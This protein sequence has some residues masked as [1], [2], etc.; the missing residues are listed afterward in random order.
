MK[1]FKIFKFFLIVGVTM[2]L[3]MSNAQAFLWPTLDIKAIAEALKNYEI[4]AEQTIQT[5]EKTN[6]TGEILNAVGGSSAVA[7]AEDAKAKAEKLKKKA[8]KIQKRA[9]WLQKKKEQYEALKKK[10]DKAKEKMEKYV[11]QGK[12]YYEEGKDAYNN[13]K[14]VYDA[15]DEGDFEETFNSGKNLYDGIT[16]EFNQKKDN[17]E[18][19][20]ETPTN[21][22]ET[23]SVPEDQSTRRPFD[24]QTVSRLESSFIQTESLAFAQI[25][26]CDEYKTGSNET[27]DFIFS[28]IIANKCCM[29]LEDISLENVQACIKTLVLAMNDSNATNAMNEH[30][31]YTKALH[32]HVAA[33]AALSLENMGYASSFKADVVDDM[34]EKSEQT[35]SVRD[36]YAFMGKMMLTNAELMS[37]ILQDNSAALVYDSLLEVDDLTKDYYETDED[38]K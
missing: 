15:L 19:E 27:G 24:A 3:D 9:E 12:E 17:E 11:Q 25:G 21:G 30:A 20:K 6:I 5:I 34:S 38:T 32:D 7:I 1:K 18:A 33:N 23:Q 2:G 26:E 37:R 14:D 29:G 28:D 8:E 4:K 10:Y 16:D 22:E 13:A 31:D 36:E 35:T